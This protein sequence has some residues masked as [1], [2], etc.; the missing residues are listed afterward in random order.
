MVVKGIAKYGFKSGVLPKPRQIL[1]KLK[2]SWEK[3]EEAKQKSGFND[4]AMV[5]KGS[6][7]NPPAKRLVFARE[8]IAN[9]AKEPVNEKPANS[10]VQKWRKESAAIRRKYFVDA[11]EAQNSMD[12]KELQ[13]REQKFADAEERKRRTAKA[14]ESEAERLTLPTIDSFLN[15]PF[16]VPRTAEE[17]EALK[18]K[19]EANRKLREIENQEGKAKLVLEL[20]QN[21]QSY[22][23]NEQDLDDAIRRAFSTNGSQNVDARARYVSKPEGQREFSFLQPGPQ[24]DKSVQTITKELLG[25]TSNLQPGLGE[26]EDALSG[27]THAWLE[28]NSEKKNNSSS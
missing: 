10:E 28:G 25:T 1:P 6:S 8:K 9:S 14:T 24:I 27:R 22:I 17:L 21:S 26:V 12:K 13:I 3:D 11:L 16:I 7:A 20:Y 15:E 19:R 23:T 2:T 4:P 18:L 5:P